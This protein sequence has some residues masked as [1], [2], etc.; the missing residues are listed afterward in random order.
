[1][2]IYDIDGPG[3]GVGNIWHCTIYDERV[4]FQLQIYISRNVAT[5]FIHVEQVTGML[6]KFDILNK[7]FPISQVDL[8]ENIIVI[9]CA[10]VNLNVKV[11]RT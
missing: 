3:N 1:M 6:K 4:N 2:W 10:S 9:K 8:L 11:V 7:N 5:I